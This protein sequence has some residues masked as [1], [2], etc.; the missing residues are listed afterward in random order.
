MA[1]CSSLRRRV[2]RGHSPAC[3]T[4]AWFARPRATASSVRL[5][6]PSTA[7]STSRTARSVSPGTIARVRITTPK[8][9]RS[10]FSA[11]T[12]LS[13]WSFSRRRIPSGTRRSSPSSSRRKSRGMV[14]R[15]CTR[16][17]TRRSARIRSMRRPRRRIHTSRSTTSPRRH[18]MSARRRCRRRKTPC[19]WHLRRLTMMTMTTTMRMRIRC[20]ASGVWVV[21]VEFWPL[22]PRTRRH[23]W[24]P[25]CCETHLI[26]ACSDVRISRQADRLPV[27]R[28][29]HR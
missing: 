21:V 10:T 24:R 2:M 17:F 5:R 11:A 25:G 20:L 28:A 15:T 3:W 16:R 19:A 23:A 18:T 14:W 22:R 1:R 9:T 26:T 27:W 7:A 29:D 4:S 12:W 8:R 13:T 6:A